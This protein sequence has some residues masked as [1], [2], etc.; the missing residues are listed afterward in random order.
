MNKPTHSRGGFTGPFGGS[1]FMARVV[2]G[3][4]FAVK[5]FFFSSF[6][7]KFFSA[8]F[9][10]GDRPLK[11]AADAFLFRLFQASQKWHQFGCKLNYNAGWVGGFEFCYILFVVGG[12][13]S[14]FC[15]I[16]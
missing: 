8:G 13:Y 1:D 2:W 14:R 5:K 16:T 9:E 12:G 10:R 15:Y 11:S 7:H 6:P 3:R 4:H